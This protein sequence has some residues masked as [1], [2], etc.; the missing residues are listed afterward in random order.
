MS[1]LARVFSILQNTSSHTVCPK[2]SKFLQRCN[3]RVTSLSLG[4]WEPD[5]LNQPPEI[6]EYDELNI[7]I[8]G[9]DFPVLESYTTYVNKLAKTLGI[10]TNSY[11]VPGK[12]AKVELFYPESEKVEHNYNL[13]KYERVVQIENVPSTLL[14]IFIDAMK[15]NAAPGIEVTI[16]KPD[17]VEEDDLYIPDEEMLAMRARVVELEERRQDLKKGKI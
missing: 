3:Y 1:I 17:L 15:L 16:K 2:C 4:K 7:Q 9:Y 12:A 6:P 8:K 11:P 14:P 10:E 13:T 5:G